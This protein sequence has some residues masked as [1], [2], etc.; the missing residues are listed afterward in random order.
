MADPQIAQPEFFSREL[1][2]FS[3]T[4]ETHSG[5]NINYNLAFLTHLE[6]R[7]FQAF[8]NPILPFFTHFSMR[9]GCASL[10]RM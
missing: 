4:T 5:E 8:K 6:M 3:L 2:F 9:S 7:I 10:M 1:R